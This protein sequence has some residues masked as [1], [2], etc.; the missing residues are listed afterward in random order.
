MKLRATDAVH[1][2]S[3]ADAAATR[4]ERTEEYQQILVMW[5]R[6]LM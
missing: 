5:H 1:M 6:W 4:Q 3:T 2:A